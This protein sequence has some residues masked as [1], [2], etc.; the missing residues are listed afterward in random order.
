MNEPTVFIIDDDPSARRGLTR[1][2]RAAGMNVESFGSARDF[3]ASERRD[4]PGCMVLDVSMPEMT[5][6]ELQEELCQDDYCMPIIF[7]SAYGDVPTAAQTLK[8]GAVD[9]LTKPVDRDDL[10]LAIRLSL[11]RDAENRAQL[12][13]RDSINERIKRLTS[14]ER[15]VMTLVI[16]GMMNKQI[17]SEMGISEETVK[18]HRGR[19]IQKLEVDSVARLV[20]ICEKVGI[21]PAE[22]DR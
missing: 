17:A 14:R 9:F 11:D 8:K 4:G 12:T 15:E 22:P 13:E 16:T 6:P 10:L 7:L 21:A 1:L 3:L 19:V 20:R 18:I 2:V 5:G